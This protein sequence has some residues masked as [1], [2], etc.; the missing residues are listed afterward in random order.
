M[1]AYYAEAIT[2]ARGGAYLCEVAPK[3]HTFEL[4]R[5]IAAVASRWQ[6]LAMTTCPY[7]D[8]LSGSSGS[9]SPRDLCVTIEFFIENRRQVCVHRV[10]HIQI[11]TFYILYKLHLQFFVN[12]LAFPKTFG[13]CACYFWRSRPTGRRNVKNKKTCIGRTFESEFFMS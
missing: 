7:H 11:Q 2:S 1:A 13:V 8:H 6:L 10:W 4:Q 9:E 3:Q 12:F 5:N